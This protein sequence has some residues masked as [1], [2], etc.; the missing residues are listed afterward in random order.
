VRSERK[1]FRSC[2]A[3]HSSCFSPRR[4]WRGVRSERKTGPGVLDRIDSLRFAM[5]VGFHLIRYF[6]EPRQAFVVGGP[7][8]RYFPRSQLAGMDGSARNRDLIATD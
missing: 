1:T 8:S 7:E 2:L 5:P 6:Y 4:E 3:S